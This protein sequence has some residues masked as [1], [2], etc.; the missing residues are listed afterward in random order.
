MTKNRGQ[1]GQAI[2][3]FAIMLPIF[4]FIALG[5]I[6]LQWMLKDAA[7]I[8]YIVTEAARCEAIMSPSCPTP[9]ATAAYATGMASRL[10]LTTTA[11]TFDVDT[12]ACTTICTVTL[13]YSYKPLGPVFPKGWTITRTGSAAMMPAP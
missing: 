2:A 9:T 10:R 1:A 7:D 13:S 3:E 8:D 4:V 12:P 5:L 11:P 6:D